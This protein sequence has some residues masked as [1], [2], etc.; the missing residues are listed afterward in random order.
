MVKDFIYKNTTEIIKTT[1]I[2]KI[3]SLV[4]KLGNKVMII[5]GK[6]AFVSSTL[7][8]D[9]MDCFSS[10]QMVLY[11]VESTNP[12]V[13]V[14]LEG[15]SIAREKKITGVLS[16]GGGS[17]IDCAKAI[18]VGIKSASPIDRDNIFE[19]L[20]ECNE[21]VPF[22]CIVTAIGSGAEVSRGCVLSNY[23][24]S[25]KKSVNSD[26]FRP[27]YAVLYPK[28]WETLSKQ[29]L[30]YGAADILSHIFERYF[31][32]SDDFSEKLNICLINQVVNLLYGY[33]KMDH[34]E[35]CMQLEYASLIAQGG[36][37]AFGRYSDGACHIIEHE[38]SASNKM[39][40]HTH[41]ICCVMFSWMKFVYHR[42]PLKFSS[43]SKIEVS[44]YDNIYQEANIVINYIEKAFTQNGISTRLN[45]ELLNCSVE[46]IA[47]ACLN[48]KSSI[49][50]YFSLNRNDIINILINA[51][52]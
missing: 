27:D 15:I 25:V 16:V 28:F 39:I 19:S 20:E 7:F 5:H 18:S 29:Q 24:K 32:E 1:D 35:F 36:I 40:S 23:Q 52:T 3:I 37:L 47:D 17:V 22:G 8:A 34:E 42:E 21:R 4:K 44:Q 43:L 12:D 48:G 51:C 6:K 9:F 38:L 45:I 50:K 2:A 14:V 10:D 33:E 13:D 26:L 46:E 11:S 49:G 31:C 30:F 41:G